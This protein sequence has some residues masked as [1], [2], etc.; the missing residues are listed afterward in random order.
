MN[1]Y[2]HTDSP[3]VLPALA[4]AV[5]RADMLGVSFRIHVEDGIMKYKVGGGSWS[6][7][8]RSTPDAYRDKPLHWEA[9]ELDTSLRPIR[10]LPDVNGDP[11]IFD[12]VPTFSDPLEEA[13]YHGR[14]LS[15]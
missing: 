9:E 3:D 1:G 7:P 8:I 14:A 4:E 10:L 6:P 5:T 11:A 13:A 12:D 15:E 2:F